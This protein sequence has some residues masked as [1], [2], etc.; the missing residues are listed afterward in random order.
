MTHELEKEIA[1]FEANRN[2]LARMHKG[3]YVLIHGA[4]LEGH[5]DTQD[6]AIMKG[7]RRFGSGP[8]LVR[9]VDHDEPA[10]S[11]PALAI[12]VQLVANLPSSD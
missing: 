1:Y 11:N 8:F 12:G 9:N 6:E 4:N 5:F 10:F 2:K 3:Q 7:V